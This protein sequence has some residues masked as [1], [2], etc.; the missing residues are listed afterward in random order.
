[1]A[2]QDDGVCAGSPPA[3]AP[4]PRTGR[5]SLVGTDH[6]IAEVVRALETECP[7]MVAQRLGLSARQIALVEATVDRLGA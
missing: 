6:E 2:E 1:M 7:E 4:H 3:I 5:P